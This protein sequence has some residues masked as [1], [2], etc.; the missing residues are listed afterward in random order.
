M[1]DKRSTEQVREATRIMAAEA[2]KCA[3][4]GPK[5][6]EDALHGAI[7]DNLAELQRRGGS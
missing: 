3:A 1:A 5:K 2:R 4:T 6:L 7:N